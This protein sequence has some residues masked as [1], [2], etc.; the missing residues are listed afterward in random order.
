MHLAQLNISRMI[1]PSI[2]HPLMADF[3]AQLDTVNALAESSDGF[4]WRLKKIGRASCRER[5]CSTV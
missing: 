5:V 1:A 2:D 4:I 3:V